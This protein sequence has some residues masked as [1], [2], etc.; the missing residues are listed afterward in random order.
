[1]PVCISSR[2]N[3]G[4][5]GGRDQVCVIVVTVCKVCALLQKQVPAVLSLEAST[6][7]IEVITA[8]LVKD[9]DDDELWF[10]VLCVRSSQGS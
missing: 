1:M 8:E 10:C 2:S 7:S 9:Q 3:R 5:T 6:I 4:V